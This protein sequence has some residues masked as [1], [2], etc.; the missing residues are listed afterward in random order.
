M[1]EVENGQAGVV[2][3]EALAESPAAFKTHVVVVVVV[4]VAVAAVRRKRRRRS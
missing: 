3:S 2:P 4:A 1:V